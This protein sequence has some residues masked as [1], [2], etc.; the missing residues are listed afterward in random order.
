MSFQMDRLKQE[1]ALLNRQTD[2]AHDAK[3]E[4]KRQ[5]AGIQENL[6]EIGLKSNTLYV[7][8]NQLKSSAASQTTAYEELSGEAE[9][10]KRQTS[11]IDSF[12]SDLLKEQS[13]YEQMKAEAEGAIET[14]NE[15]LEQ[16]IRVQQEF[17]GRASEINIDF[18]GYIQKQNFL[19][20]NRKRILEEIKT[21]EEEYGDLNRKSDECQAVIR[22]KSRKVDEM[23]KSAETAV[24]RRCF[25]G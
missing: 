23:R 1:L 2:E 14:L 9:E 8:V 16:E 18:S 21:L 11:E 4:N 20:E 12:K 15:K 24:S 22:E 7:H 10:L 25:S 17:S 19:E 6:Q 13:G 5:L 3:R